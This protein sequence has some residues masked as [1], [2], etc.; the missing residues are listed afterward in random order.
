MVY[1]RNPSLLLIIL[2]SWWGVD[3]R[4]GFGE[5]RIDLK[6]QGFVH[7]ET[8]ADGSS[9]LG[10]LSALITSGSSGHSKRLTAAAL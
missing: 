9:R 8:T 3:S 5:G 1:C 4:P 6:E 7:P 10:V 2:L